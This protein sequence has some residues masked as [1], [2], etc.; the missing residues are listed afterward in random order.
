MLYGRGIQLGLR[1]PIGEKLYLYLK[2]FMNIASKIFLFLL[3]TYSRKE[4]LSND[5]NFIPQLLN[6]EQM[7]LIGASYTPWSV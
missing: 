6:I 7:T 4:N 5:V 3:H 1:G 2:G